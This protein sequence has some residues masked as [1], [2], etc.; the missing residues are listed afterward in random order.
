[1][2]TLTQDDWL[3]QGIG[4]ALCHADIN[5]Q[6]DLTLYFSS[7]GEKFQN[8]DLPLLTVTLLLKQCFQGYWRMTSGHVYAA[9]PIALIYSWGIQ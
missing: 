5:F 9:G 7:E 2:L 4:E 6:D 8:P 1:M 3:Y